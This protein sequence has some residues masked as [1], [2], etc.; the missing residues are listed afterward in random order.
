MMSSRPSAARAGKNSGCAEGTEQRKNTSRSEGTE[1]GKN[2]GRSEG[3][4][5]RKNSGRSEGTERETTQHA[6]YPGQAQRAPGP[7][8]SGCWKI[9]DRR[10][11]CVRDDMRLCR[12]HRARRGQRSFRRNGAKRKTLVVPEAQSERRHSTP[13]IPAKRSAR[14]D[15]LILVAGRSRIAD[16]PASGMTLKVKALRWVR[17]PDCQRSAHCPG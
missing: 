9:P 10:Q 8:H 1:R 11:A 2:S 14:R 16:R 17:Y 5:P 4:E 13:V 6:C 15:R 7:P 12:R 3:T